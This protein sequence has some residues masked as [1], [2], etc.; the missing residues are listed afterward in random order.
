MATPSRSRDGLQSLTVPASGGVTFSRV[1][2]GD[3]RIILTGVAPNCSVTGGEGQTVTVAAGDRDQLSFAVTC[4]ETTGS[5]QVSTTVTGTSLDPDG[6]GLTI[7]G[8]SPQPI[9]SN[10]SVT[11]GA[12]VP[13][14]HSVGLDGIA[15]NCQL[16]GENPAP[17]S[18][19]AGVQAKVSFTLDCPGAGVRQW[20]PMTGGGD[21]ELVDVWG[22]GPTDVFAVGSSANGEA[23]ILHYDGSGWTEQLRRPYEFGPSAFNGVWAN[24]PTDAYAVGILVEENATGSVYHY[25]GSGWTPMVLPREGVDELMFGIWGL[26]GTEIYAFGVKQF[27]VGDYAPLIFRY[28]GTAWQNFAVPQGDMYITDMWGTSGSDLYAVGGRF[29]SPTQLVMHYNGTAWTVVQEI[30]AEGGAHAVWG[31]SPADVFVGQTIPPVLH[32]DG[33]AWSPMPVPTASPIFGMWG[34]AATDVFAATD[35]VVL[36][37]DGFGWT[38]TTLLVPHRLIALWGSSA[39]DVFAV[40]Q[41]GTILRGSP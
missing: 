19:T 9:A 25:D 15:P 29:E 37:Y 28:D 8:A 18:V 40:G 3:R 22:T 24:T 11:V 10:S 7:D 4:A 12:L 34:T 23:V 14:T 41:H 26:S 16:T 38:S 27:G 35:N 21:N 39:T 31:S 17:I 5:V 36:H 6:Y 13:G 30:K 2:P 33:A 32:F 1:A 20:L